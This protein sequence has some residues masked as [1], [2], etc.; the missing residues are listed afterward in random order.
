VCGRAGYAFL[1]AVIGIFVTKR[2]FIFKWIQ[3]TAEIKQENI[4][5]RKSCGHAEIY[6]PLLDGR[7]ILK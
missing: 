7:E 4:I 1:F 6:L 5:S 2:F 3:I